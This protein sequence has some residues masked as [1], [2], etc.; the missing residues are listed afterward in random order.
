M[1]LVTVL[2]TAAICCT[3]LKRKQKRK[4]KLWIQ[5][6]RLKR[7]SCGAAHKL[8]PEFLRFNDYFHYNNFLRMN[9]TEFNHLL[10]LI[11][12]RIQ[13][14]NTTYRNCIS[15]EEMLIIT[16]RYLAT[17]KIFYCEKKIAQS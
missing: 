8:L 11:S 15:P 13:K 17:G 7:E 5:P 9:D 16:L 1:L 14:Q 12:P 2:A 3:V 4:K 6:W 10:Q